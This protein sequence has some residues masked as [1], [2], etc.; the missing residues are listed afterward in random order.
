MPSRSSRLTPR[1]WAGVY[2]ALG[3]VLFV[4][5]LFHLGLLG[6]QISVFHRLLFGALSGGVSVGVIW[7]SYWHFT[8][9][10]PVERYRRISGWIVGGAVLVSA[11]G[12][13]TLYVGSE[14]VTRFELLESVHLLGSLGLGL[15]FAFGSLEAQVIQTAD[16]AARAET[17]ETERE[18]LE[19][20][21]DL[22][23]HYVLNGISVI[24][25]H[26]DQLETETTGRPHRSASLITRRSHRIAH[27]VERI[28]VLTKT[29]W[30][31]QAEVNA[32]LGPALEGA[33]KSKC[34]P[35]TAV[36]CPTAVPK[37]RGHVGFEDGLM[38][39]TESI[40]SMIEPNGTV[41]IEFE[42]EPATVSV[43]AIPVT[44][45]P[46]LRA[47]L[48]QPVAADIGLEL[49]LAK[50]ILEPALQFDVHES[51]EHELRFTL[52]GELA[53]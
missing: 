19:I 27:L 33:I 24:A 45:P 18:R 7:G 43:T 41:S 47:E 23:R 39:L 31:D 10:F 29:E 1:E 26:A 34:H 49:Y 20:L 40:A 11:I 50:K 35:S 44:V 2:A 8:N 3:V 53:S 6:V 48:L 51:N 46:N 36:E 38:L 17:L 13:A 22:L 30:L 42:A 14:E 25:G 37:F 28:S 12:I 21:N 4:L 5:S 9:P 15:G 16:M 52:Q 32:D